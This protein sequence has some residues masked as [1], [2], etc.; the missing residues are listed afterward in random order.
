MLTIAIQRNRP[1]DE[2]RPIDLTK[3]MAR[4]PAL[5]EKESDTRTHQLLTQSAILPSVDLGALI[6]EVFILNK[7]AELGRKKVIGTGKRI[8]RQVCVISP[9]ASVDRDVT[10]Y[11]VPDLNTRRFGVITADPRTQIRL[12]L[13][14]SRRESQNEVRQERAGI[15]PGR[16]VGLA[17]CKLRGTVRARRERLVQ[18]E[19]SPASEAIIKEISF[20]GWPNPAR[21]K[22]VTEFNAAKEPDVIF[23]AHCESRSEKL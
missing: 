4:L 5:V 22:D 19:V 21:T 13:L 3:L 23:W 7:R 9:T 15:D 14:I 11:R 20:N 8:E 16:R 18:G 17:S 12:E 1:P 2:R 6:I 10:S